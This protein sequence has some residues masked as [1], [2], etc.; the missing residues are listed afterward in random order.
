MTLRHC[1]RAICVWLRVTLHIFC[2]SILWL[3]GCLPLWPQK[4]Q[5]PRFTLLFSFLFF[6]PAYDDSWA[7][8]NVADLCWSYFKLFH[9]SIWESV[10]FHGNIKKSQLFISVLIKM[11]SKT[12][13][14][15]FY[16][17]ILTL[18]YCILKFL[19]IHLI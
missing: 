5:T 1:F 12:S 18:S 19:F 14:A 4:N 13:Q 2:C 17:I 9:I 15:L 10:V 16:F 3:L 8:H 7:L 11:L 6:I